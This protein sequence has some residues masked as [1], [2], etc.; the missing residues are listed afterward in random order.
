MALWR[1]DVR[2]GILQE[3]YQDRNGSISSKTIARSNHV[4]LF[5]TTDH[6]GMPCRD[7]LEEAAALEML[8]HRLFGIDDVV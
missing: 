8:L 2:S 7:S 3:S 5:L 6:W 1:E 4:V